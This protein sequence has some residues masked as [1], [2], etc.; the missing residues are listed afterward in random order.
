M[1]TTIHKQVSR[2]KPGRVLPAAFAERLPDTI[3]EP[4]TAVVFRGQVG[5]GRLARKVVERVGSNF[6]VSLVFVA[7]DFTNEASELAASH[8]IMLIMS[9]GVWGGCFWSDQRLA[10]IHTATSTHRPLDAAAKPT[11]P[12]NT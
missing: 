12:G 3:S 6:G 5:T 7:R 4:I 10:E 8:G 11:P 1:K 2:A 9:S